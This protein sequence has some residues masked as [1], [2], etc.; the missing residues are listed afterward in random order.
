VR[1]MVRETEMVRKIVINKYVDMEIVYKSSSTQKVKFVEI[2]RRKD[3][4]KNKHTS[5]VTVREFGEI[6]ETE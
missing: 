3:D 6:A 5:I 4:S 2:C 1:E